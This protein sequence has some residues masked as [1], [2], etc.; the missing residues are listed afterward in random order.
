VVSETARQT[1][2]AAFPGEYRVIPNGIDIELYAAARTGKTIR[3]RVLFLG[4]PEPRKGLPALLEAFE[5]V[6]RRLPGASLVLAGP[7]PE[8]LQAL[9]CRGRRMPDRSF[10][11]VT[12]LGRVSHDAKI[13]ELATAE[14]L[15]A[16]SNGGESFGIVLIE[17]MAAGVPVIASDIP[18]YRAVLAEGSAGVLVPPDDPAALESALTTVLTNSDLRRDLSLAGIA[19]AE[20][21]SWDRLVGQVMDA[22]EEAIALG[23]QEVREPPVPVFSQ[24]RHFLTT[25]RRVSTTPQEAPGEAST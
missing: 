23:P 14:V 13:R 6:R 19:R 3:G 20:R 1:V 21:Y 22:Y 4:R 10:E 8:E 25:K 24:M 5:G 7:T 16:P 15:C 11:G 17:A 18:G 9:A 2:S 12:A